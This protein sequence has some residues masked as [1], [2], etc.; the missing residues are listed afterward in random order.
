MTKHLTKPIRA[1]HL[2]VLG[3]L[4]T[5]G[6]QVSAAPLPLLS[7]KCVEE[8]TDTNESEYGHIL[9]F[10]SDEVKITSVLQDEMAVKTIKYGRYNEEISNGIKTSSDIWVGDTIEIIWSTSDIKSIHLQGHEVIF[11]IDRRKGDFRSRIRRIGNH[12]FDPQKGATDVI[13]ETLVKGLCENDLN[14]FKF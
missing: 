14:A 12:D 10:Y 7:L 2:M 3:F 5:I 4:M 13:E 1:I 6:T 9:D 11:E 8:Q